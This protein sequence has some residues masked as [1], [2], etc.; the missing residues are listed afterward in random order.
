MSGRWVSCATG[1]T[2]RKRRPSRAGANTD[3]LPPM[4]G[5]LNNGFAA[6]TTKLSPAALTSAALIVPSGA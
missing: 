5:A 1:S 6:P 3:D 2:T 4:N